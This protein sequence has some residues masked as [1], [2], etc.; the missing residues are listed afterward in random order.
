MK[1]MIEQRI[2]E[3]DQMAANPFNEQFN[4]AEYL[5]KKDELIKLLYL[6]KD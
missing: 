2:S 6:F 1:E 4:Y 3:L 5:L